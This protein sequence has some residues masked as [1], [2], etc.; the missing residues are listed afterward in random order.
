MSRTQGT[1]P[2]DPLTADGI[3]ATA[4]RVVEEVGVDRFSIRLLARELGVYPSAVTW[5]V[6]DRDGLVAAMGSRWMTHIL[7]RAGDGEWIDWLVELAHRYR[8]AAHEHPNVAR[9]VARELVNG[10]LATVLPEAIVCQL[11]RSGLPDDELVHAYN[12][13]VGAVVGFV[14][15]ELARDPGC[16][17][18]VTREQIEDLD[19]ERY[20]AL[21]RHLDQFAGRAFS[22]RWTGATAAMDESF[23]YLVDLI[24]TGLTHRSTAP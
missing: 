9:L 15:L 3:V 18:P 14:D 1:R 22:L 19:R 2:D 12:T 11:E 23:A 8:Q 5:H 13:M 24:V 10:P 7:P 4:L 20:P 6:G 21:A 16:S 17:P